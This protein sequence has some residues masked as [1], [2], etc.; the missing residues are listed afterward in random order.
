VECENSDWQRFA[1]RELPADSM[2]A[3]LKISEITEEVWKVI[4]NEKPLRRNTGKTDLVIYPQFSFENTLKARLYTSQLNIAPALQVSLW[5]GMQFTG[6]VIF[7][8]YNQLGYEG[9]YIRP[10]QIILSQE[11]KKGKLSGKASAGNFSSGRYGT[12]LSFRYLLAGP[13]WSLKANAGLTGSSHFLDNRWK[14]SSLNTFT[15]SVLATWF[16]PR[17]NMEAEGGLRRFIY[18]DTGAYGTLT[19]WFGETSFAFYAMVSKESVNGGFQ[20]CFPFPVKKRP[21]NHFFR[22]TLPDHQDMVY[23]AGTEYY[24]GQTYRVGPETNLVKEF[25]KAAYM[26]KEILKGTTERG[27][28]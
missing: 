15:W 5:R 16:I 20:F 1:R 25:Y 18:G 27:S 23:N 28:D 2:A 22:V 4:R 7:P 17:F 14:Q 21:R 11:F 26:K 10:G 6:Q 3:R 24:Y 13:D 8:L 12:D 19:R 9:D